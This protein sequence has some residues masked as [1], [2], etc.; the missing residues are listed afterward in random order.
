MIE[1]GLAI[2]RNVLIEKLNWLEQTMA[3]ISDQD[4]EG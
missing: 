1:A 2:E 4:D 3:V